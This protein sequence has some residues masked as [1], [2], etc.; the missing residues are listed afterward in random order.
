MPQLQRLD[1]ASERGGFSWKPVTRPSS[2]TT[3]PYSDGSSTCLTAM[4]AMPPLALCAARNAVRS[5]SVSPSPLI[6]TKVPPAK[7]SRKTPTPPAV[8]R[9]SSSTLYVSSTPNPDPSPKYVRI[10]SG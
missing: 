3:T 1:R 9:S 5:M 8:P 7:K 4:V 2:C 6:T 10:L